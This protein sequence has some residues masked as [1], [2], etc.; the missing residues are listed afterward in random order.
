M[1]H[2]PE[3]KINIST[4]TERC[5]LCHRQLAGDPS[6]GIASY[7][8][9]DTGDYRRRLFLK[10]LT[11]ISLTG[12]FVT[13]IVNW[14]TFAGKLWSLVVITAILYGWVVCGWLTFKRNVHISFKLM[15]HA[16]S[17]TALLLVIEAF[18]TSSQII[19]H[20]NWTLSFAMP[21]VFIAFIIAIN[22]L[23]FIKRQQLR[24]YLISQLSLSVIGFTPLVLVLFDLVDPIYMSIGA[25]G[26]SFATIIGLFVLGRRIVISE[27]GRKF[28]L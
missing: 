23:M 9:F 27:L 24:D 20:L 26:L 4:K 22:I 12:I 21:S 15:V 18:T 28:H 13:A 11:T 7:P 10:V 25:A 17:I 16:L 19:T 5:P 3:C 8:D 2:C 1:K 14:L 6:E